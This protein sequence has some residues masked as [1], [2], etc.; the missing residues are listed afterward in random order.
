M[1]KGGS[2]RSGSSPRRET[3][4]RVEFFASARTIALSTLSTGILR[5]GACF[6]EIPYSI[7][8]LLLFVPCLYSCA[9]NVTNS[10]ETRTRAFS[11]IFVSIYYPI[12]ITYH[13]QHWIWPLHLLLIDAE[14]NRSFEISSGWWFLHFIRNVNGMLVR[15]YGAGCISPNL[16]DAALIATRS[17]ARFY[18]CF[19]ARVRF[20]ST[21][22]GRGQEV[23]TL[24]KSR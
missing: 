23:R 8:L 14:T 10:F 16:Y 3:D 9:H 5:K 21:L 4:Y 2:N 1:R 18:G 22:R 24:S 15:K 19:R 7:N 12:S 13:F 20:P 17:E 11:L 6:I